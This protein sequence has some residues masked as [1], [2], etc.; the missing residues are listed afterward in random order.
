LN[1]FQLVDSHIAGYEGAPYDKKTSKSM[2]DELGDIEYMRAYV[3][4]KSPSCSIEDA[5]S[6]CSEKEVD[7]IGKWESKD[8]DAIAKELGRLENMRSAKLTAD[9]QKWQS[10]RIRLLKQFQKKLAPEVTAKEL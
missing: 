5:K 9:L 8:I 6:G 10:Q 7:F 1:G 2:C 4:D 3:K